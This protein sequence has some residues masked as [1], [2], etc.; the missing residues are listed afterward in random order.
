LRRESVIP[1][2]VADEMDFGEE[3]K[4]GEDKDG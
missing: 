2:M 4:D 3:Q 1:G